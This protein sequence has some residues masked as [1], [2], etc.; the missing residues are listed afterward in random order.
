MVERCHE[1]KHAHGTRH[2]DPKMPQDISR[3]P[4]IGQYREK[5]MEMRA[6][7][8]GEAHGGEDAEDAKECIRIERYPD[9]W[10]TAPIFPLSVST[11]WLSPTICIYQ[12]A[13]S[14][15]LSDSSQPPDPISDLMLTHRILTARSDSLMTRG[16]RAG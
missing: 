16:R 12:I 2:S 4:G 1:A 5:L 13:H 8:T 11:G 6:A 3:Y 14:H 9:I 7:H 15:Y 10:V